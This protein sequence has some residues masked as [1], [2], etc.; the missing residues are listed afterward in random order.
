MKQSTIEIENISIEIDLP[1]IEQRDESVNVE[2]KGRNVYVGFHSLGHCLIAL[3]SDDM[4]TPVYKGGFQDLYPRKGETLSALFE[5][6]CLW[7]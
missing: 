6:G 4:S 1:I 3:S 2:Y 7:L 5:R